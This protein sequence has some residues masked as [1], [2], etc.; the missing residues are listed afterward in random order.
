[1]SH[2]SDPPKE[3]V[4]FLPP[5]SGRAEPPFHATNVRWLCS[6]QHSLAEHCILLPPWL[7]LCRALY[8]AAECQPPQ[9]SALPGNGEAELCAVTII[10][11]AKYFTVRLNSRLSLTLCRA[12]KLNSSFISCMINRFA[13]FPRGP[14]MKFVFSYQNT[15]LIAVMGG[16]SGTSYTSPHSSFPC[17]HFQGC[18]GLLLLVSPDFNV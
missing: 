17:Q 11:G 12:L 1:M 10:S 14:K 4:P 5:A 6:N 3:S 16:S 9:Q 7:S 2:H 13:E 18:C 15:G 8:P